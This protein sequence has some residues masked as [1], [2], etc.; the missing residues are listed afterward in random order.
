MRPSRTSVDFQLVRSA[1]DPT[2]DIPR[3]IGPASRDGS[4]LALNLIVH[5]RN[6]SCVASAIFASDLAELIASGS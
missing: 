4:A 1:E 5:F 3:R 6:N 2:S